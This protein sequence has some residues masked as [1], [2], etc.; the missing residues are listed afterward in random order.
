MLF[1]NAGLGTS[2]CRYPPHRTSIQIAELTAA[3][4][5]SFGMTRP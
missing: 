2:I 4:A 5:N 3:L 1:A